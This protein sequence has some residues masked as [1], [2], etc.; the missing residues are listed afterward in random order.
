MDRLATGANTAT[1]HGYLVKL[2]VRRV[3]VALDLELLRVDRLDARHRVAKDHAQLLAAVNRDVGGL[4]L[5]HHHRLKRGDGWGVG[6]LGEAEG[7]P[8]TTGA[9]KERRVDF[10]GT[11]PRCSQFPRLF[12]NFSTTATATATATATTTA[13]AAA[14]AAHLLDVVNVDALLGVVEGDLDLVVVLDVLNDPLLL[15]QAGGS[16]V[17]HCCND[18][19][20]L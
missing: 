6:W 10:T 7:Q 8:V 16:G 18:L 9:E 3:A 17:G 2:D 11:Q 5:N 20:L 12:S 1:M 19:L 15:L 13:V 14:A 4:A